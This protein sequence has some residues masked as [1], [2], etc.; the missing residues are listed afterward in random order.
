MIV[1]AKTFLSLSSK[2][3]ALL[4][5]EEGS[6]VCV[7]PINGTRRWFLLEHPE[8]AGADFMEAYFRI[9]GQRHIELY[10]LFFD[11]GIDTLLTPI[12]GPELLQRGTEYG[13]WMIPAL[14]WFAQNQAFLD[15]Y[16]ANDV[17]V[18][19]YGDTRRHLE[20][21]PYEQALEAYE[22]LAERTAHHSSHRLFFGVCAHDA[23]ET[24][25]EIG[26]RFYQQRGHLPDKHQIVEAYYGEYVDPVDLFI[27][28]DRPATFDMPLITTG[29][30]DLYF[31]VSPSPYVDAQTL[32]AILYDHLYARKV[33]E[34]DYSAL[35]PQ[36]WHVLRDFYGLN[37]HRV[38]GLGRRHSSGHF[39]YPLPQVHLVPNLA[40]EKVD[41]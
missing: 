17:R 13:Q 5:R 6:K 36:D 1:D 28:F 34:S 21:T 23:T 41:R 9:G 30:E 14:L 11:H 26:V 7:F 12:F 39:W 4:V 24:V 37:R 18:R 40:E 15:F 16:E 27:G 35:A 29:N 31:T 20:H 10:K 38:L 3:V 25:A 2:Q 19:I 8:E 33:D 22:E 32:R